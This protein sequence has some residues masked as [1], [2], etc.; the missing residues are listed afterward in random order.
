MI[1][2]YWY[3]GHLYSDQPLSL[4]P[5]DPA[6]LYGATVF[7]TLRVYGQTLTDPRTA[8][9]DHCDR[10]RHSL[11]WLRWPEP[12]WQRLTI[13]ATTLIP[14]GPVLRLTLFPDG[15]EWIL[16]RP[17]PPDLERWQHQ[18]IVAWVAPSSYDRSLPGHKT[19]NYLAP[20]LARQQAQGQ[21]A[22]EA[23]LTNSQGEW[24]ETATGTLWGW[25]EGGWWTPPL[26]AGILPG[27]VR[28]RLLHAL[29][30]QGLCGGQVPWDQAMR[31]R[32]THLAYTN[33]AVEVVPIRVIL[34]DREPV[35]YNPDQGLDA[36]PYQILRRGLGV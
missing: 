1:S 5:H 36:A 17:L 19:G 26:G 6:L 35:N 21:G 25:G 4:D 30:N 23:I 15:R 2:P 28:S 27:V 18:G 32:L 16:P 9:G 33:S 12:D 31:S 3:D 10:L 24:L 22:E 8:W 11:T 13:G 7:T 20:G 34:P 29:R 14:H